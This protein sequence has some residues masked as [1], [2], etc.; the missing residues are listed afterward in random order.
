MGIGITC[1][2]PNTTLVASQI[3]ALSGKVDANEP[4]TPFNPSKMTRCRHSG[5]PCALATAELACQDW[6]LRGEREI[7]MTGQV[8]I[9]EVMSNGVLGNKLGLRQKWFGEPWEAPYVQHRVPKKS[10][11]VFAAVLKHAAGQTMKREELP[12]ASAVYSM[13]H[14][15]RAKDVFFVGAFLAAKGKVA[16]VLSKFDFG[17]G[18]GLV[19]HTI[20]EAD[21][22]TPLPGPFYIVNFGPSKDCFLPDASTNIEKMGVDRQT[23]QTVWSL[24]YL[25]DGDIAVS[26]AALAGSDLWMCPGISQGRIF[27]SHRLV[28]ALRSTLSDADIDDFELHRCRV[29]G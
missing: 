24:L 19:P 3:R 18:G 9:S 29:L 15:K 13:S 23:G 11:K 8:W 14:F 21:E 25:K 10:E 1:V 27:M 20:Y 26:S 28:E 6:K 7:R 16:E 2:R 22:K 4:T 5:P 12:E 17:V